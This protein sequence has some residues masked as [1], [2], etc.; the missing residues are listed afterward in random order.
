MSNRYM[1]ECQVIC[2]VVAKGEIGLLGYPNVPIS[3]CN[4]GCG[5]HRFQWHNYGACKRT[6]TCS[7]KRS[8]TG[9]ELAVL[10]DRYVRKC[11]VCHRLYVGGGGKAAHRIEN[12]SCSDIKCRTSW[13]SL[14]KC[15]A[16]TCEVCGEA[17]LA[18]YTI[19]T[20]I[21]P[22]LFP[23]S[24]FVGAEVPVCAGRCLKTAEKDARVGLVEQAIEIAHDPVYRCNEEMMI[25]ISAK[26]GFSI[27]PEMTKE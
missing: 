3:W 26:L 21:L 8:Y 1:T 20:T 10:A 23:G 13:A 9:G 16:N 15:T 2:V 27:K 22:R 11:P 17:C 24:M 7:Y 25:A 6:A 4:D 14:N 5:G 18:R 12:A 19:T